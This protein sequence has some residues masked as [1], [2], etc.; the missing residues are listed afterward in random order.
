MAKK[1]K[2]KEEK[3]EVKKKDPVITRGEYNKRGK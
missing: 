1:E 2:K 3:V